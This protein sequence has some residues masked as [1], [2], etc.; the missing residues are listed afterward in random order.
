MKGKTVRDQL[1]IGGEGRRASKDCGEGRMS[2]GSGFA[3]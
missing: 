2:Y 1:F 3:W